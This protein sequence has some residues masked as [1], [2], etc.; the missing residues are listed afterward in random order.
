METLLKVNADSMDE[1]MVEYEKVLN[2]SLDDM[3]KRF[4][5]NAF[6]SSVIDA[7]ALTC[8]KVAND[9]GFTDLALEMKADYEEMEA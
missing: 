8:I 2:E 4:I 5:R 1:S 6:D 3:R 7:S 9:L